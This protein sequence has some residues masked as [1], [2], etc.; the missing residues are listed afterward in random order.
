MTPEFTMQLNKQQEW[1]WLLAIDLF[2]GGLGGGLFLFY[3]VFELPVSIG[4]LSLGLVTAGGLV[5][6]AELGHPL[7]AWRA[8]CKPFS[9][10]ISRCVIFVMLFLISGSLYVAPALDLF[11]WLPWAP[12]VFGGKA[13]GIIAGAC[14]FLVTLYPGFVLAASPSIPFWNNPLLPVLFFS[15]S[16]TGAA[17]ILLLLSPFGLLDQKLE[18]I[19]SL[20]A[21]LIVV[22]FV[23]IAVYLLVVKT[24]GLAAAE[25][26]R[27][28]NEGSLSWTFKVGVILVGTVF[29]LLV[30]VWMPSAV[31]LAGAFVLI[32]GLLF[33][34]CVLKSGV[35]VPFA[36]T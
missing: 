15:S 23:L 25:S 20:V 5:L 1:S 29:P 34:Y 4:L 30:V 13:L 24:S 3:E 6:L 18:G 28:L 33:R 26:V 10:W 35:Y 9:S 11:S 21:L 2:L 19:N 8:L 27:H 36:L 17:G 16:V 7:R 32:G 14:A 31:V 12:D 22:N